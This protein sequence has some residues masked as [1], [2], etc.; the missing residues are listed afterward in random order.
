MCHKTTLASTGNGP[1]RARSHAKVL[2]GRDLKCKTHRKE[3]QAP[4]LNHSSYVP[5]IPSVLSSACVSVPLREATGSAQP[6]SYLALD[7]N[8][9]RGSG[10]T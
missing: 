8:G 9:L 1:P 10:G 2:P 6:L 3:P 7:V 4:V 5:F